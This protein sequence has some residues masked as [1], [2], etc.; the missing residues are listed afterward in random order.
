MSPLRC[1]SPKGQKGCSGRGTWR[2]SPPRGLGGTCCS[3]GTLQVN[4]GSYSP[5]CVEERFCEVRCSK[6]PIRHSAKHSTTA[7]WPPSGVEA[8]RVGA[9]R[10]TVVYQGVATRNIATTREILAHRIGARPNFASTGSRTF[11]R[12]R[13]DAL[14]PLPE[15]PALA[16]PDRGIGPNCALHLAHSVRPWAQ[17]RS[18]SEQR[19]PGWCAA[20]RNVGGGR[21]GAYFLPNRPRAT[22][23]HQNW[24]CPILCRTG[25]SL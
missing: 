6:Q 7:W 16:S 20:R 15:P 10:C 1:A 24:L 11:A 2:R 3:V 8:R 25:S 17:D 21:R 4:L 12:P 5:K 9:I 23:R 22:E 13:A 18:S 14:S 19:T